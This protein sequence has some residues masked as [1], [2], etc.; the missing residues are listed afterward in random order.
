MKKQLLRCIF[1]LLLMSASSLAF[2]QAAT[3]SG[4][5]KAKDDGLPIPS[6]SVV[7]KGT[8]VGTQTNL[9]GKFSLTLPQ[10]AKILVFSFIGY[11][12]TEIPIPASGQLNVFLSVDQSTLN[13]VV[14]TG[15]GVSTSR[16]KLGIAVESLSGKNLSSSPN[17]SIDQGLVGQVAGAQI[18]SVDGTPGSKTNIILRGINT[19]QG[20]TYPMIMVDGIESHFTDV[21]QIDPATV[22]HIEIVQGAAASSIYGAQGA[23][24]VIQ[25]FS[26]KGKIGKTHIDITS[27]GSASNIVNQG[28]VHQSK[29]SSFLTD[30]NGNFITSSGKPIAIDQDGRYTGLAWAYGS[31]SAAGFP[32][33]MSNP[34]N[35]M[36][37]QYGTN[38]K[39][40][41]HIAQ[42]FQTGYTANNTIA[43]SGATENMD[44]SLTLSNNHQ[45]SQIKTN[46]YNDRT[47]LTSNLGFDLFKGFTIRSI[48]QLIYT[49]NNL[50]YGGGNSGGIYEALNAEPYYDFTHK[51][52]D[53]FYPYSLNSGTVSVNGNNPF[54]F[55]Q[56]TNQNTY[57]EDILQNITAEYKFPKFLTLNAK[58]G[59]N[60]QNREQ[61][62]LFKNQS[63]T[64]TAQDLGSFVGIYAQDAN[65]ELDKYTTSNVFQNFNGSAKIETDFEKDFHIKVPI[66][67]STLLAYDYRNTNTKTLWVSALGLPTYNVYNYAQSS[68]G[69]SVKIDSTVT[70]ITYGF[71]VNQ[72]IDIG[73]YGGIAG[74]FRSDYS[75]A[76]GAGSKP[77]TFPTANAYIRP[78]SFSFWKDSK[79]GNAIPEFK[80]RAAFG[81]AGTQPF[82]FDRYPTINPQNIGSSLTFNLPTTLANPNLNVELSKEFEI[83]TDLT[84]KGANGDWFSGFN[85]SSTYWNRKGSNVI[86]NISTAPSTGGNLIKTNAISLASHGF[87]ASLD[88][89]VLKTR[90]INWHFKTLFSNETST[91]TSITGPPIILT[92]AAGSTQES[93]FAG[94]KIGQIFG[95]KALTSVSQLAQYDPA[96]I[97][98]ST[99]GQYSV[100]NGRVVNNITKAIQFS[101]VVTPLGDPNPIFNMSFLNSFKYK[102]LT[103]NAQVDWV[104]GSHLYNQTKEW[105]YRD[106]ISGDYENPVTIAGTT[107][108]YTAYYRS[109]YADV[110]GARNGARDGTK[111]YFYED[112]SFIR[113][114][115]VSLAYD[116]TKLINTKAIKRAELTF[117]GR[118]ILTITKYTGFDPEISS[119]ASDSPFDRGVDHD[120]APNNKTYLL[121]LSLGF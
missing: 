1:F 64:L 105:Q 51:N 12:T 69:Q 39:Y 81:E 97:P 70:F 10:G 116:F 74:G 49:K 14:V 41:D 117:T 119:G 53:G 48:T 58:Y 71:V 78:S 102:S 84:I 35:I 7:V 36:H 108:A 66:T 56:F 79:L 4:T 91:I 42:L 121:G 20:S 8:K 54:Y 106:G 80:I 24:G 37:Q 87:Q 65:G 18:S 62:F 57:R 109:A 95:Y 100:V 6:V 118:N 17:A 32:T 43:F 90:D 83:G 44:Y 27:N 34:A 63:Q 112:A 113:L 104:H 46:G 22:D 2:S 29:L 60:F 98:P 61:N 94:E 86:Y 76:F 93:L 73:S 15:S 101:N 96:I 19:L 21:S 28:N 9:E 16:A 107:A 114:R 85:L 47:N 68:E 33:A 5:V 99:Y 40:Y 30:A 92:T 110:I 50:L 67:T 45:Q 23:N 120:S 11:K 111:D 82:P 77:F 52:P 55:S 115:S 103:F 88:F 3:V 72:K 13:E 75:S 25:I 89:D 38:L 31:N 26:K 59:L